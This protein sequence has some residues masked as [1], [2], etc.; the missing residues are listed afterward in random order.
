V[1]AHDGKIL[2]PWVPRRGQGNAGKS[3]F[4]NPNAAG[5]SCRRETGARRLDEA[6]ARAGNFTGDVRVLAEA[7]QIRFQETPIVGTGVIWERMESTDYTDF[8]D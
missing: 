8:S 7:R 1:L 5:E 4:G 3:G 6:I 2:G